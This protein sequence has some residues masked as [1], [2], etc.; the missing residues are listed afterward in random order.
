MVFL[1]DEELCLQDAEC[2]LSSE[3]FVESLRNEN[4]GPSATVRHRPTISSMTVYLPEAVEVSQVGPG[5]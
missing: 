5:T 1:S 2:E 4:D 3:S